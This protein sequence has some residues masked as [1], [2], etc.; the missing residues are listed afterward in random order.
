MDAL[1]TA[2]GALYTGLSTL[3]KPLP[4]VWTLAGVASDVRT[5]PRLRLAPWVQKYMSFWGDVPNAIPI[6]LSSMVNL[7]WVQT[8]RALLDTARPMSMFRNMTDGTNYVDP[9]NSSLT[10]AFYSTPSVMGVSNPFNVIRNDSYWAK[11]YP[12]LSRPRSP[13]ATPASPRVWQ[14][15]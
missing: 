11:T 10:R 4:Y 14:F 5:A 7:A 3:S 1:F 6:P 9:R 15:Y 2:G 8:S 12:Y 13:R